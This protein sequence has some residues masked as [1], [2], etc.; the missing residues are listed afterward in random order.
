MCP[1]VCL[2]SS[3]REEGERPGRLGTTFLLRGVWAGHPT[4]PPPSMATEDL[5]QICTEPLDYCAF[6]QCAHI[7]T[8]SKCVARWRFV[9]KVG[10]VA[11]AR[12]A[13]AGCGA[14][15]PPLALAWSGSRQTP[16][17]PQRLP[18]ARPPPRTSTNR[19]LQSRCQ[20][21]CMHACVRARTGRHALPHSPC[22]RRLLSCQP[23][24]PDPHR[25][26]PRT[27]RTPPA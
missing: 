13:V 16:R 5:C 22:W 26:H 8:C 12:C 27:R 1:S 7:E 10:G 11:L 19:T 14:Y 2:H 6:G 21:A 24:Q 3:S 18:R 20:H 17:S 23:N 15:A 9:N 25:A 4:Q